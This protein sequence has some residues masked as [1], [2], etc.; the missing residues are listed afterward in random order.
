MKPVP[1]QHVTELLIE[2]TNVNPEALDKLMPV[3]YGELRRLARRYM[4]RERADHTLQ[5]T[6]LVNEVYLKLVNQRDVTWQNRAHFFGVTAQLM[7]RIL[8]D[9]ARKH[10]NKK[11]GGEFRKESL[12]ETALFMDERAGELL[13]LDDALRR[14]SAIDPR[15]GRIVELR[16][17]GGLNI[18]ETAELM[19]VSGPTVQREWKM[20]KAWLH[21]EISGGYS[22]GA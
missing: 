20:A 19:K 21:R 3:V 22:S 7:R 18:D 10:A 8:V 11:R 15:K 5:P 1:S 13:A 17:F 12:D 14:L 2:W 6:A 9:H 16:Y 4:R